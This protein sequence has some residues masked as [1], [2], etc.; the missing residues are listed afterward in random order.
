[1]ADPAVI[2]LTGEIGEEA[3]VLWEN[4]DARAQL[5]TVIMFGKGT[6]RMSAYHMDDGVRHL[7][8]LMT[9]E[10][11]WTRDGD[12][13]I[14]A[15]IGDSE[16]RFS[17]MLNEPRTELTLT[18]GVVF[19]RLSMVTGN[20]VPQHPSGV[21]GPA[22]GA[23]DGNYSSKTATSRLVFTIVADRWTA[24]SEFVTGFGQVYDLGAAG[25][26]SGVVRGYKLFDGTGK[27]EI[28]QVDGDRLVA[29]YAG[30]PVVLTRE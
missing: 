27:V 21:H 13:V 8:K 17:W 11:S 5:Y 18:N 28:G 30:K 1:M 20:D 24:K 16:S 22:I 7:T 26:P 10:G 2:A 4:L 6:F 15:I 3:G 12:H 29:K 19:S 23:A 9:A 14:S 25:P